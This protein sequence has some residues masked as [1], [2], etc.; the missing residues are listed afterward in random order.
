MP[1]LNTLFSAT[2]LPPSVQSLQAQQQRSATAMPATDSYGT[3]I[4][5]P[6]PSAPPPPPTPSEP[7]AADAFIFQKPFSPTPNP[8]SLDGLQLKS[9][10][11]GRLLG[12]H[13]VAGMPAT[14]LAVVLGRNASE[15]SDQRVAMFANLYNALGDEGQ[16]RLLSLAKRG[17]LSNDTAENN[18]STLYQCYALLN[19][20]RAEGLDAQR[21]LEELVFHLDKPTSI[22]Q[23]MTPISQQSAQLMLAA[24]TQEQQVLPNGKTIGHALNWASVHPEISHSC[25]AASVMVY[26]AEKTPSELARHVQELTSPQLAFYETVKWQDIA[27]T[28]DE[29]L[30][31]LKALR[32]PYQQLNADT[33]RLRVDMSP[34][35]H[36]RT[37]NDNHARSVNLNV[38]SN[39][40]SPRTRTSVETAYQSA[41]LYLGSQHTFSAANDGRILN[42]QFRYGLTDA[43]KT[44]MESI[45]KDNGGVAQVNYQITA[46][47]NDVPAEQN[48]TPYL[49]GYTRTFQQTTQD[50]L[51]ALGQ[52]EFV[53]AGI[54]YPDDEGAIPGG[55]EF[56][57]TSA[58]VDPNTNDLMFVT[59]DT[60]DAMDTPV[61]VAARTLIPEI[62]H[63]GMPKKL[64]ETIN[65]EIEALPNGY[66]V[67]NRMDAQQFDPIPVTHK[68][69][70]PDVF[71]P[72]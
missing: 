68:P 61:P 45:V 52:K 43:E 25:V 6:G 22:T 60:D 31:T 14:E 11:V 5:Q 34:T 51:N 41:L 36:V 59:I 65:K 67:P 19:T 21:L 62:H 44:V 33:F 55:H 10:I 70:P 72:E 16:E 57:I 17:V 58:Y 1:P 18:H 30:E 20:P 53:I 39:P 2:A 50:I 38:P 46:G 48:N 40:F 27:S 49:Y 47:L 23:Q 24:G 32:A 29:A 66:F 63:L 35:A 42:G 37:Y 54:S 9:S 64:G 13:R 8:V 4:A 56:T 69:I 12:K 26:M 71:I 7:V 28:R 3:G 15:T